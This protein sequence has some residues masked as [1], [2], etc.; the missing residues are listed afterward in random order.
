MKNYSLRSA[1]DMISLAE[2]WGFLPLFAG[3]IGGFSVEE[4]TPAELWFTEQDGPWEWKG[5]AAR[6][7]RLVYGK[8]F[9]GKAGMVSLEWLPDF[10]N[11]RRDGYDFDSRYE[12]GLSS[13]KDKEIVA[14]LDSRGAML[15]KHL[16]AL[17]NYKKG[18]NKGFE[19]V[20]T[21][22]Q[23]Q[24]YVVTR[25]F[26]YMRDKQGQ[27]YGWGVAEYDTPEHI[28][29]YDAVTAAY[30]REPEESRRRIYEHLSRLLPKAG[31]KELRR[32]IG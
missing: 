11:L 6:S 1:E 19:T 3:R 30:S 5:P 22:L 12:E 21:R 2:E 9:G 31:E 24:T 25:D 14:A 18:G 4:H 32:L 15:S 17:C 7:C 13:H 20:I 8:F 26:V 27:P 23:M 29:G 10:A 28:L 16:K